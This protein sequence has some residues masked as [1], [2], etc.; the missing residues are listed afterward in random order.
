MKNLLV[1]PNSKNSQYQTLASLSA[2]EPPLWLCILANRYSSEKILDAEAENLSIIETIE[3]IVQYK[4][5]KVIIL[6]SG[7]HPSS[8]I[9]QKTVMNEL[10]Y[11]LKEIKIEVETLDHLPIDPMEYEYPRWDLLDMSKYRCHNWQN[12]SNKDNNKSYGVVY[13]SVSCFHH[14]HFCNIHK[15]YATPYQ[16]RN[17][18]N[19]LK[20][21]HDLYSKYNITNFKI[22]DELFVTKAK[23]TYE[24][25][26]ELKDIGDK[27]NIWTYARIDTV[28]ENL[29][30]ALKKA[31]VQ[32]LAYGIECGSDEIRQKAMKGS[33][34]KDKIREVV[35]MT[36]DNGINI[37]GN[38]IFGFWGD[39]YNTMK[40]TLDFAK[41]LNCEFSNF[42]CM[43]AYPGSKF[44]DE[45][46]NK[47]IELS[48]NYEDYAQFSKNFKP[49]PTRHLTSKQVLKFRDD[50]FQDFFTSQQYLSM[51]KQRFG[52]GVIDEINNMTSIDIKR[53]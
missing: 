19:V 3:E 49:L 41:E 53:K 6:S 36:K 50:A 24:I 42:Y 8:F 48:D 15:F 12:F 47:G 35:K 14:C 31:G 23:R 44:Y 28:D 39:N 17:V 43:V 45:M 5:D 11:L 20:D 25:L 1:K 32:W 38:Y 40:E 46:I 10:A 16:Q 51:M 18:E 21:F 52:D 30:K 33:F 34:T 7:N 9:Q 2:V 22:M 26:D 27:I 37:I 13:S 29:L 4:P